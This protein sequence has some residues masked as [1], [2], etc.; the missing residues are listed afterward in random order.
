GVQKGTKKKDGR[1]KD[2]SGAEVARHAP[3]HCTALF[4]SYNTHVGRPYQ[5]IVDTNFI[6]FAIKN[7]V[8]CAWR[9]EVFESAS[10][11]F[12]T[13]RARPTAFAP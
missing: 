11:A 9:L 12:A 10:T 1:G 6:N 8:D 4:F 2:A 5:V 7:Q 13:S 3:H